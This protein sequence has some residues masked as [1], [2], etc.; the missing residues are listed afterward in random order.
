VDG[1][2][3]ALAV[4]GLVGFPALDGLGRRVDGVDVGVGRADVGEQV[5][6]GPIVALDVLP[7]PCHD[8]AVGAPSDTED[9]DAVVD[10]IVGVEA[11]HEVEVLVVIVG[12]GGKRGFCGL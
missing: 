3:A 9:V 10:G 11:R 1:A 12:E 6:D 8:A 2:H 4:L 7:S 5:E